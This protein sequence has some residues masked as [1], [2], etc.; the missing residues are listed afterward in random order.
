MIHKERID[1]TRNIRNY[2]TQH[3]YSNENLW[4]SGQLFQKNSRHNYSIFW[5]LTL[6]LDVKK[7]QRFYVASW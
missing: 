4:L 1:A 5:C 6:N 2:P 7:V 3:E